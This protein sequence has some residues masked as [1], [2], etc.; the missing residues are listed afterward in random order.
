[1]KNIRVGWYINNEGE[2]VILKIQTETG[3]QKGIK[4]ILMELTK[5]L[6][7][8]GFPKNLLFNYCKPHATREERAEVL[9]SGFMDVLHHNSRHYDR[10]SA[11]RI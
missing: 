5:I 11:G 2:R 7:S 6:N 10:R 9:A 1:V 4:T 3:A 8:K